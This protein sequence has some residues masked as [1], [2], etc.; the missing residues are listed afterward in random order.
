VDIIAGDLLQT[1]PSFRPN[2]GGTREELEKLTIESINS[3]IPFLSV[4]SS[5]FGLR[6]IGISLISSFP[7]SYEDIEAAKKLKYEF[8]RFGSDK[9]TGHDYHL[10]YG[11]ILKNHENVTA[12]FE[13]GLGTNNTDV[14]SNMGVN[15]KPGASLR[16][17]KEFLENAQIFGADVDK[18][19]LFEEERIKTFYADQMTPETFAKIAQDIPALDLVIDDGLHSPTANITTLNFGL[20]KIK[21]GGW[22]VIEDIP[23]TAIPFWDVVTSILPII[24]QPYMFSTQVDL[25]YAVRKVG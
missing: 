9:S 10:L 22:V 7:K 16:A 1:F 6:R 17:F 18:R 21:M 15:G 25:V 13:V 11:P 24:Y 20:Q 2:S 3:L 8:D 14:A 4:F 23:S 12:V 19:I 5:N